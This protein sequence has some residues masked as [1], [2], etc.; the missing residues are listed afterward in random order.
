MGIFDE[1]FHGQKADAVKAEIRLW[2]ASVLDRLDSI[3]EGLPD[4]DQVRHNRRRVSGTIGPS[5]AET[6]ADVVKVPAGLGWILKGVSVAVTAP[7]IGAFGIMLA[8]APAFPENPATVIEARALG[9]ATQPAISESGLDLWI[10][11][12]S[13]LAVCVYGAGTVNK[14]FGYNLDVVSLESLAS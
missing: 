5:A 7:P 4:E 8:L 13:E 3:S 2:G 10:P 9:G 12:G 6:G 11:G 14:G 1:L